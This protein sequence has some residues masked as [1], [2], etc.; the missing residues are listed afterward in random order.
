[1]EFDRSHITTEF[2]KTCSQL[3][4]LHI[5]PIDVLRMAIHSDPNIESIPALPLAMCL[6]R[7]DKL[8]ELMKFYGLLRNDGV[9]L[10]NL[11]ERCSLYRATFLGSRS[12]FVAIMFE[13]QLGGAISSKTGNLKA[14]THC[15]NDDRG[16]RMRYGTIKTMRCTY[17]LD[18]RERRIARK[19]RMLLQNW[20][21]EDAREEISL[22]KPV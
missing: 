16:E 5:N 19:V 20:E 12:L 13:L 6:G 10:R 4:K 2:L 21:R 7:V 9:R 22:L 18:S 3:K 15:F 8:E 17:E 14:W 11:V 1:M